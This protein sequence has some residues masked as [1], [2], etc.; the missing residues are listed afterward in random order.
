MVAG[1]ALFIYFEGCADVIL[2]YVVSVFVSV[3]PELAAVVA[4]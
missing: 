4:S 2:Y 1:A 3:K